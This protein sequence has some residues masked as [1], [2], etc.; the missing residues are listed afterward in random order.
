[1]SSLY[2]IS[3]DLINIFNELEANEGEITPELENQLIITK[4]NLNSKIED[5]VR[6]IK[7]YQNDADFCKKEKSSINVRQ[8][9]YKNRVERLKFN[10]LNAV[11]AFGDNGKNNKYIETATYRLST[12]NGVE[13]IVHEDRIS[14][15]IKYLKEYIEEITKEGI[16]IDN[17]DYIDEQSIVDGVNMI[18]KAEYGENAKLFTKD[19]IKHIQIKLT[20]E[21]NPVEMIKEY[22]NA[23][24]DFAEDK[25]CM[26]NIEYNEDKQ[27]WKTILKAYP[28]DN[29]TIAELKEK[30]SLIIK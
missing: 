10:L 11:L 14:I 19:D 17:I 6:A 23:I 9:V 16:L 4:E 8:N 12:R 20:F 18:Y 25:H 1:M 29:V 7:E 15:L 5:Y 2:K 13:E 21:T 3:E 24:A 27:D 22:T 30:Q 28:N 26:S